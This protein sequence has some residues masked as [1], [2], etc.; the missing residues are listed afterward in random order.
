MKK[1]VREEMKEEMK[2][3]SLS[4]REEKIIGISRENMQIEL[5]DTMPNRKALS[6]M[7]RELK[8]VETGKPWLVSDERRKNTYAKMI[9]QMEKYWETLFAVILLDC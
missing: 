3:E 9:A 4:Q 2:E 5:K 8:C 6:A 1:E 7:A